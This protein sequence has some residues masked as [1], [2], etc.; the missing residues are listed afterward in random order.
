MAQTDKLSV[1]IDV[2]T[3]QAEKSLGKF[4]TALSGIGN[5]AGTVGKGIGIATGAIA[6]E[7]AAVAKTTLSAA[8]ETAAY[9]DN[10]DKMSQKMNMSAEGYQE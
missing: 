2:V 5:V 9:G 4:Q 7:I 6:G 1:L 8:K 10:I 3:D